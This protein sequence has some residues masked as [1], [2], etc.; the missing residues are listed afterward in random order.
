MC[1]SAAA[2]GSTG[3]PVRWDSTKSLWFAVDVSGLVPCQQR[4]SLE[5][6]PQGA[7]FTHLRKESQNPIRKLFSCRTAKVSNGMGTYTALVGTKVPAL[8]FYRRRSEVCISPFIIAAWESAW[9]QRVCCLLAGIVRH[10]VSLGCKLEKPWNR[11]A[12]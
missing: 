7:V 12:L 9:I 3:P 2:F 6:K 11:L 10:R 8:S 4:G 5:T 1:A